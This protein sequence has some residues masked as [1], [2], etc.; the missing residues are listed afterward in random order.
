MEVVGEQETYQALVVKFNG[1][2]RRTVYMERR[3]RECAVP[4]HDHWHEL[5]PGGQA[6]VIVVDFEGGRDRIFSRGR[7]KYCFAES[8]NESLSL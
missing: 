7:W 1:L 6:E 2:G 3:W 5:Q 4:R 8:A